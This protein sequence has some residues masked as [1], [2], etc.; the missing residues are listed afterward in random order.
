MRGFFWLVVWVT[1]I[2]TLYLWQRDLFSFMDALRISCFNIVSVLTTTGFGL[3]DFGTWGPL[4]SIVFI[5][6]LALGACSGST[7]GGLKIFR[8]QVAF[9]LFR[10]QMRQLMHPSAVFPQKYNGRTVNDAIIRSMISFVLAYFAIIL[11][12]AA[13]LAA[14]GLD[15]LTSISSSITAVANVGPGMGPVVG[16]STNFASLPESAKW[17]LSFGMLLGRLEIL[18]VAVLFFP[19]FWRQ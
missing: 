16:P 10:K 6:L 15:P 7:A 3:G 17:L 4:A 11:V 14:I 1:A 5:V 13:L 18:T 19:S 8:V 12:I 2:M 9:A